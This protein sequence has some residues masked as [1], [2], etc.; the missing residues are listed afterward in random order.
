MSAPAL[1]QK[2]NERNARLA[3]A[4]AEAASKAAADAVA[5]EKSITEKAKAYEAEYNAV[6]ARYLCSLY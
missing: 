2:K 4:A 3:K 1:V 6:S 5:F